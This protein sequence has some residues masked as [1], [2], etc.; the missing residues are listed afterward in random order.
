MFAGS[1]DWITPLPL[2][3]IFLPSIF[4]S[5]LLIFETVCLGLY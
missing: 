2:K 4:N 1:R 5:V 3:K